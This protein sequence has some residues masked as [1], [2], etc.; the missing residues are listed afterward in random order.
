MK[1]KAKVDE[2]VG[3]AEQRRNVAGI[4]LAG[5]INAKSV[6]K[7]ADGEQAADID[8]SG[9]DIVLQTY[10]IKKVDAQ[11]SLAS[12]ANPCPQSAKVNATGVQITNDITLDT[13][14]AAR[15]LLNLDETVTRE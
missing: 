1:R 4:D 5:K 8:V 11:A 6:F 15:A 7:P 9:S 3:L 10:K 13:L 14:N 2:R 12:L